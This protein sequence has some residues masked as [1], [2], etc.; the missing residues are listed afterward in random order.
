MKITVTGTGYTLAQPTYYELSCGVSTY[1]KTVSTTRHDHIPKSE[2]ITAVLLGL[3]L[4]AED[5]N[6]AFQL[7]EHSKYN[8][9]TGEH[10]PDGFVA[11]SSLTIKLR[12]EQS[13]SDVIAKLVD[14][15]ATGISGPRAVLD[16]SDKETAQSLARAAAY[17]DA[18]QKAL[19]LMRL[20]DL[21]GATLTVKS[22]NESK[23]AQDEE[24]YGKC[25]NVA[26]RPKELAGGVKVSLA[27]DCE[28]EVSD[29]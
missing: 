28:F 14:I 21:V 12:P 10:A 8:R 4:A 15:G 11:T 24:M 5:I 6:T 17:H 1:A 27:L 19:H 26:R 3:G 9:S 22:V 13:A 20:A 18:K 16:G 25:S 23:W 2:A 7:S 29:L